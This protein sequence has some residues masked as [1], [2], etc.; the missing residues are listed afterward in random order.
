MNSPASTELP[1][2]NAA[3]AIARHNNPNRIAFGEGATGEEVSWSAFHTRATRAA[4]AYADVVA[5]GDRVAFLTDCSIPHIVLWDGAIKAGAIVSNLH[6]RASL[7]TLTY[8]ID[9]LH[10]RV[11]VIDD[12][13]AERTGELLDSVESSIETVVATGTESD[14][15]V[16][17]ES[18]LADR[19]D[20][21]PDVRLQEDDIAAIIWTSGTTGTP[22]GW[23]HTH[24]GLAH[25]AIHL[26]RYLGMV[27]TA[28]QP[29]VF[30][31]SFAAWYSLILPGLYGH[32]STYFLQEWDP[33][34]FV[35]L[36]EQQSL[37]TAVLIPTM[38]REILRLDDLDTYDLGSLDRVMT[39][40]ERL[41]A[42][43]L[44]GLREHVCETVYNSYAATE[45]LGTVIANSELSGDR[46]ESV[47]KPI[48]GT[49]LRIV[50]EG[51]APDDTLPA[52]ELGEIIIHGPDRAVWAWNDT[53]TTEEVFEEGWWYSGDLGYKDEDGYVFVEGRADFMLKSKG[54]KIFPTPI[55]E[56]IET[57]PGVEQVGV[58]GVDDPEYGEKVVAMVRRSNPDIGADELDA[59][60]VE[61][62]EIGRF[63]RPREYI[64]QEQPLP[65]TATGKLDRTS[66]IDTIE[67]RSG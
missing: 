58:I 48:S 56:R 26:E 27:R 65:K 39:S 31:P 17:Y 18:F 45:V 16:P 50:E 24:R 8:C 10:P 34:S 60:C 15:T 14:V 20:S 43:T 21:P 40:G 44:D 63:E 3:S 66:I 35:E 23:C 55:E 67:D 51:R 52:G 54:I 13:F 25:K 5:Q 28:R 11:L 62:E 9:E 1:T 46:I 61:S 12:E 64:F 57:H 22:K 6:T 53:R 19:S 33:R 4:N 7:E 41:D 59:W 30:T 37:T 42:S 29:H 49:K 36:I 32:G 2:L 38:W 47:G